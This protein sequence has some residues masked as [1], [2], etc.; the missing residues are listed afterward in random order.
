[1]NRETLRDQLGLDSTASDAEILVAAKAAKA[2]SQRLAAAATSPEAA[3]VHRDSIAELEAMLQACG[4][5]TEAPPPAASPLSASMLRD[6]GAA[7]PLPSMGGTGAEGLGSRVVLEPG[8]VLAQR[9]EIQQRLGA[10][11]MGAVFAA[12]DRSKQ[13][14]IAIKVILPELVSKKEARERFLQ[15]AKVATSLGHPGIVKVFDVQSDGELMFLTMELLEGQT[16]RQQMEARRKAGQ[17]YSV[18][19]VQRIVRSLGET[20]AYAHGK[21]V[22]RDVKPENVFVCADGRL[23]LMDFGLAKLLS[24]SALSRSGTAMGT[25]YYMAPEQLTGASKVDP[26]ADQFALGVMAYELLTGKVPTGMAQPLKKLRKDVPAGLA[27][28]IE[29]AMAA[30]AKDRHTDMTT[31]VTALGK[32]GVSLPKVSGPVLLGV[33]AAGLLAVLGVVFGSELSAT[34]KRWLRDTALAEAVD[35]QRQSIVA[36]HAELVA[37]AGQLERP[38]A[39]EFSAA[40]DASMRDAASA[41]ASEDDTRAKQLLDEAV[42]RLDKQRTELLSVGSSDLA[43]KLALL[44]QRQKKLEER[45]KQIENEP[46]RCLQQVERQQALLD[47]GQLDPTRTEEARSLKAKAMVEQEVAQ[48]V[49]ELWRQRADVLLAELAQAIG[50]AKPALSSGK[51]DVASAAQSLR[52]GLKVAQGLDAMVQELPPLLAQADE[53]QRMRANGR[54]TVVEAV[55]PAAQAIDG[56]LSSARAALA[57]EEYKVARQRLGDVVWLLEES[58]LKKWADLR[59]RTKQQLE[60]LGTLP[61]PKDASDGGPVA[62]LR[63]QQ[64]RVEEQV[65][66]AD[67]AA[68]F[69]GWET[70][71]AA[72]RDLGSQITVRANLEKELDDQRR[73][74]I[75]RV[76]TGAWDAQHADREAILSALWQRNL[77]Q[78]KQVVAKVEATRGERQQ[79]LSLAKEV[80]AVRAAVD[81]VRKQGVA[82]AGERELEALSQSIGKPTTSQQELRA[83]LGPLQ[84]ATAQAYASWASLQP[85][86]AD[87]A[88]GKQLGVMQGWSLGEQAKAAVDLE[89]AGL[90]DRSRLRGQCQS[91]EDAMQALDAVPFAQQLKQFQVERARGTALALERSNPACARSR[92][93]EIAADLPQLQSKAEAA[94]LADAE[95]LAR[96]R[97]ST[98]LSDAQRI[99]GELQRLFSEQPKV[100]ALASAAAAAAAAAAE[101]ERER[102]WRSLQNEGFREASGSQRDSATGLPTRIEHVK[103]GAVLVL[104]PAGEFQMG[105]PVS[106]ADRG[107]DETQHRRVIRQAF[108]LGVTE[109]TQTQ[110]EKVTGNNPS[111]FK[112]GNLPVEQVS[113]EDCQEFLKQAGGGL[114][115]PSE[116]EWE[117]ACR[118][119]TTTPF[120][121][122][123]TIT[124]EQVNYDGNYPYGNGRV[125]QYRQRT[126]VAGSLPANAWGL[127]EM[128]GNVWEW[129]EDSSAPYPGSGTEEPTRAAGARV[130]RGGSWN[131][132]A[133]DCR[134]ANRYANSPDDRN[135]YVG[136]RL[137]RTLP[138]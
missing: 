49:A 118:A 56:W 103:T 104:I 127:H 91:V 6:L 101:A 83:A 70:A 90:Q 5:S 26:R 3:K 110:W 38:L 28:A 13:E 92:L 85:I 52:R 62:W 73:E 125:G 72:A 58:R 55:A 136:F 117:Y 14:R 67:R 86:G 29:N 30:E 120:S 10:G 40:H 11:G 98:D 71:L 17:A 111:S 137:A 35:K 60:H 24:A 4:L 27:A 93:V 22:H 68:D 78:A 2:R 82:A 88:I 134:A 41:T 39:P 106:E 124:P 114:R 76:P 48:A 112:G 57:A 84:S 113:W 79:W 18:D 122:G 21:T 54:K 74:A 81:S 119:G 34:V 75:S 126:V 42:A 25:A 123:A 108:Y 44:E 115:L 15:E 65:A 12:Y 46:A 23:V 64:A 138:R 69:A 87:E 43:G 99:V 97:M 95:A 32:G 59:A 96:S 20:L 51:G 53:L 107:S 135:Y 100:K 33:L 1:M 116:A 94:F 109:V 131:Y 45:G 16:L 63:A 130:L 50:A 66:A 132:N 89:A 129:C 133:R 7:S 61:K 36:T 77:V 105:S 121:F 31:L 80:V 9:Y 19:E 8:R 102:P 47:A 128:H 37:L